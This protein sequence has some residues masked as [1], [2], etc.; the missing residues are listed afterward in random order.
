LCWG[1]RIIPTAEVLG[2]IL[3]ETVRFLKLFYSTLAEPMRF[4]HYIEITS[5]FS[6]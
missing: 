3:K 6:V 5:N 1:S 4:V 2:R